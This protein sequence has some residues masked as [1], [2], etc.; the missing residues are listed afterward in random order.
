MP[1]P[2]FYMVIGLKD[3]VIHDLTKGTFLLAI[4]GNHST[5]MQCLI[6]PK[7]AVEEGYLLHLLSKEIHGCIFIDTIEMSFMLGPF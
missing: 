5:D 3:N 6:I 1:P 7:T 2:N 4:Y